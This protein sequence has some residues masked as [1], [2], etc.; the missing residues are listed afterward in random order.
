MHK[1]MNAQQNLIGNTTLCLSSDS[2]KGQKALSDS[3]SGKQHDK[4]KDT[5]VTHKKIPSFLKKACSYIAENYTP[6]IKNTK[7]D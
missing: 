3:A 6:A 4:T 1:T 7:Q 2:D 5:A